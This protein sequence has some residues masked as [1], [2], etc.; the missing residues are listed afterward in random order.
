MRNTNDDARALVLMVGGPGAGKS[1]VRATR[2]ATLAV[3]DCDA[4]KAEHPDYNPANPVTTHEWSS[5]QA[6]RRLYAALASG[7]SV[8][9]D[10]TGTNVDKLARMARSAQDAGFQVEVCYVRC[11]LAVALTRNASRDRVVPEYVVREKHAA[12]AD[13]A[14]RLS[15]IADRYVVIE[16]G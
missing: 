3:V 6:S 12:A 13:A 14:A 4:I 1:T 11:P 2:Y 15:E 8:V 16:N 5:V 7:T 10:S 9:F